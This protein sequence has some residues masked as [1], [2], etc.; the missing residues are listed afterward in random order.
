MAHLVTGSDYLLLAS[1][2]AG[3]VLLTAVLL[4]DKGLRVG[5]LDKVVRVL[6]RCDASVQMSI[7]RE[8]KRRSLTR[9]IACMYHSQGSPSISK[10][11]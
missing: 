7:V 10:T 3:G 4:D 5:N 1:V 9:S 2:T 6:L 8:R 11:T